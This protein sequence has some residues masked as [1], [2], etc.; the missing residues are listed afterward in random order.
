M[1]GKTAQSILLVLLDSD[2]GAGEGGIDASIAAQQA[3]AVDEGTCERAAHY[4][5]ATP[6]TGPA[7]MALF[8][9]ADDGAVLAA[10]VGDVGAPD[11]S[12]A[13]R[14]RLER[15]GPSPY[16]YAD[17]APGDV[18]GLLL[19]SNNPKTPGT[20]D[21]FNAWY[22]DV[23][24]I[25]MHNTGLYLSMNRFRVVGGGVEGMRYLNLYD[26]G[27]SDVSRALGDLE[28]FRPRWQEAGTFYAD[29][30]NLLRGAYE[31]VALHGAA[32]P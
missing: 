27:L 9:S 30:V 2:D 12:V 10:R 25:D 24:R 20:D 28:I 4:R 16:L 13:H 23:H 1:F 11:A 17:F 14:L 8:E 26:T 7:H 15:M 22:D 3:R 18:T 19:M 29:R 31:L 6:G 5:L 21:A 32:S